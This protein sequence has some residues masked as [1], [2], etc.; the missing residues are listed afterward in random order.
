MITL[1][2]HVRNLPSHSSLIKPVTLHLKHLP[3]TVP[4]AQFI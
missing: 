4:S 1:P 2:L 3:D